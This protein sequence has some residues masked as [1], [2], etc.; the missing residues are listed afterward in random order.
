MKNFFKHASVA[1]W[2][3]NMILPYTLRHDSGVLNE[4]DKV[5]M[6]FKPI[7]LL[8][9]THISPMSQ[10]IMAFWAWSLFSA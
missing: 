5:L 8:S 2:G 1:F 9:G 3:K 10:C 4:Y 6:S 7:N